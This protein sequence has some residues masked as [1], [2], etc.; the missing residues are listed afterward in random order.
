MSIA[1]A[2]S[3]DLPVA[4]A[5]AT[6]LQDAARY[7]HASGD[8][9]APVAVTILALTHT[10]KPVGAQCGSPKQRR[11][12]QARAERRQARLLVNHLFNLWSKQK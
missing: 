12:A 11:R 5:A 6:R 4:F 7:A 1:K 10:G 8:Y 2:I 3:G 9:P